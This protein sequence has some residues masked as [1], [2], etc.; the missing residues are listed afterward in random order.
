MD[1][2]TTEQLHMFSRLVVA[3]GLGALIGIE[4]E[5]RGYP[6]GIRTIGLVALGSC[7]FTD[8][9][10]LFT[11]DRIAAGIVTGIGFLGAGVIL[12][13]QGRIHGITTAATIWAAAAIGMATAL[14]LYLLAALGAAFIVVA[15]EL[16]PITRRLDLVLYGLLGQ[17]EESEENDDLGLLWRN[18]E[19]EAEKPGESSKGSKK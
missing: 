5:V 7:L 1:V 2:S 14:S 12:Q 18:Q 17:A 4:R 13:D 11:D 10:E 8:V 3:G 16:R 6:A 19:R 15:L 9:S